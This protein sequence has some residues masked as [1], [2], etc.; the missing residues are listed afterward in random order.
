M[1]SSIYLSGK[2]IKS[3]SKQRVLNPHDQSLVGEINLATE[4][5]IEMAILEAKSVKKEMADL[6]FKDRHSILKNI[7]D[8]ILENRIY[9]AELITKESGKPI[10][11]SLTE[12]DRGAD[13]FLIAAE[14][15]LKVKD[16][17]INLERSPAS[18][19]KKGIV[20]NFPIG[21]VAGITPF[22]FP[23]NLV[24]HK[25]APAIATGCPMILKPASSTPLSALFLAEIIDKT[26]LPKGGFQVLPCS[27]ETGDLL[28][29]DE[30]INLL[31]FTG[32]PDVGWK[33]KKECGKKKIVLELGGN[34][35]T[36]IHHDAD[37]DFAVVRCLMGGFAYS[38]QICIH[39]QRI[40]L[41]ENI[42]DVFIEKFVEKTKNLKRGNPLEELT[43]IAEMIDEKN[44]IRVENWIIE[45]E[46]MGAKILCGGKRQGIFVE[47]TILTNTTTKMKVNA[48]E[49]FGPVVIIEKCKNYEE[50]IFMINDSRFGL[51]AGVFANDKKIIDYAFENLE[52]GGVI[53]N[54][55][56]TFR[57]D[58]MPYGGVKD[59]GLGREGIKYA[60]EDYWE[61][62][63][64]VF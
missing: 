57:V 54:D 36:Y 31:S 26:T 29:K 46:Q 15:V 5:E 33:M 12:T 7:A 27:R 44:A 50:G 25:V 34:A 38:G 51:Q 21:I 62:K 3:K 35:G 16:E 43:D 9:I 10:R 22:N 19:D 13:T 55:V 6:S 41:H 2:F 59:S 42:F 4:K 63:V 56:P 17:K 48:E 47:P 61:R 45:A 40:Y 49:V 1:Q 60:M 18:R 39:A 58:N 11:Y 23:L 24:A 20:R 64:I 14:E 37:I 32:S 8:S 28:V 53:V 52:V 30:R